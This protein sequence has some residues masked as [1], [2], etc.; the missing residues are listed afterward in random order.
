[1]ISRSALVVGAMAGCI[2]H[3]SCGGTA[4]EP[5][6][7]DVAPVAEAGAPD[8]T[9]A[10]D[11]GPPD[12]GVFTTAP[13]PDPRQL[14]RLAGPVL[15]HAQVIP[16]FYGDDPDRAR[17]EAILSQLPGSAYWALLGE[18]GVGD[19]TIAPSVVLEP[20]APASFSLGGIESAIATLFTRPTEPAPAPN[21]TQIYAVFFPRQTTVLQ[22][23]G[24]HFCD[25]G[26]AYHSDSSGQ[27]T[28]FSYAVMP[29]CAS[30]FDSFMVATTHEL[31]ETATDP[32]PLS[33]PAWAG[34]D[35]NHVGFRGEIGDLCDYS[36][37]QDGN[38]GAPL[39]GTRVERVFSNS[40]A[41]KGGDPCLP[42]L[43]YAYFNAAPVPADNTVVNDWIIGN[44]PGRGVNVPIGKTRAIN[45]ALY[46][47][48]PMPKWKVTAQAL[49]ALTTAP[50][51]NLDV[52]LDR[53]SGGNG[54]TLQ[55][56]ITRKASNGEG[57]V[58]FLNSTG[59]TLWWSDTI[60]VGQ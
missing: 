7:A 29:H 18:Y 39:F 1:M 55:L 21:G 11:A 4:V 54:D 53:S 60:Y 28:N 3:A 26:G 37:K 44:V 8:A 42:D 52:T 6:A 58:I 48:R 57:D 17:T 2:L 50:S 15:E 36:G 33:N 13:H 22:E 12:T 40:S 5:S 41:R 27:P 30:S 24:S 10:E 47:D 56:T 51:A 34:T 46:S 19:L 14:V 20:A 32:L 25:A 59:T 23:D 35:L 16:I 45:V 9:P 38:L 31:I 43:G 49:S